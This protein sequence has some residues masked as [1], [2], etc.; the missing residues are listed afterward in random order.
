[1]NLEDPAADVT[2]FSEEQRKLLA[3]L[4]EEEGEEFVPRPAV[5]PRPPLESIPL[6][7]EQ[8]RLWFLWRL[9]PDTPFYNI[10]LPLRLRGWLAVPHLERAVNDVVRRHEILRTVFAETEQEPTQ[11]VNPFV[12][13]PLTVLDLSHDAE[14]EASAR[15]LAAEDAARPADLRQGP[16]FRCS[17]LKLADDEHMLLATMHHI[18]SDGW[19]LGVFMRE[20]GALYEGYCTGRPATL[21]PLPVQYADYAFWQRQTLSGETLE[22]ELAFCKK[23]LE[24][25]PPLLALP[26]DRPRPPVQTYNGSRVDFPLPAELSEGVTA[27]ARGRGCTPFMVLQA[28]FVALLSRYAGAEDVVVGY[29][30]A[31]RPAAETEGLIGL[32]TN[33]LLLRARLDD[34]PTF[35]EL[36]ERVKESVLDGEAHQS[37][38]FEKLVEE[39]RPP[40]DPS[41]AP[42]FQ[43]MFAY[44]GERLHPS[45]HRLSV[46]PLHVG[47]GTAKFDLS[48]TVVESRRGT[49]ASMEYNSDLFERAT[50]ER[51]VETFKRLLGEVLRRPEGRVARLP[52]L[53]EAERRLMLRVGDIGPRLERFQSV[54]RIFEARAERTPEAV[55]L[56][57][58]AARLTYRELNGRANQLAHYLRARGVGAET[59]VGLCLDKSPELIVGAL[60]ILKAG[61]VYVPL[62]PQYPP[63]RLA[64]MCEDA[65]LWG[66]LSRSSVAGSLPA[67]E[68]RALLFLDS[69]W[70]QVARESDRN[71][72]VEV[73]GDNL[74]YV[75]YTSGSTGRPKGVGVRHAS[76]STFIA[77]ASHAYEI[78]PGDRVLQFSSIN[79]DASAE[80]IYCTL[81]R[82]ATLVLRTDEMMAGIPAF[83][84]ECAESGVTVLDLPTAFW[85]EITTA[86]EAEPVTL[87]PTLRLVLFGGEKMLAGHLQSWRRHA[88][89]HVRVL[90]A[91]GPTE[92]TILATLNDVSAQADRDAATAAASIGRP[93]QGAQP[94]V[95]D[96]RMQLSLVGVPGELHI[97]GAGLARGYLGRP[98]LTAERFVPHPFADAPGE[99]LYRTGDLVRYLPDGTLEF[100]GRID[101]QVKVRGFR[102]ELGEIENALSLHPSVQEAAVVFNEGD[103]GGQLVAYV[104]LAAEGAPTVA[105][106]RE[107]LRGRLPD[108]MVPAA[109]V[110]LPAFPLTP[111]GKLDRGALPPPPA[112]S[113][114]AGDGAPAP[115]RDPA[116]ELLAAL[117]G[118]LLGAGRVGRHDNF[119]DLGGHS[120]L[121][122]RLVSRLR[123]LFGVEL[124]LR[125]LFDHPTPAGLAE[126]LRLARAG[127][128]RGAAAPPVVARGER[129]APLSYA[130]QRLWFL[131]QLEAEGAAY[132]MASAVRLRGRLDA[133]ALEAAL[134]E[135]VRRHEVLRSVIVAEGG[136]PAQVVDE[137][138]LAGWRLPVEALGGGPSGGAE[139]SEGG[140]P[141]EWAE[142]SPEAE[143]RRE[144]ALSRLLREEAGRPFRLGREWP[145]RA[146]LLRLSE[147]E[148]VLL[149]VL[150]HAAADGWS[151][152]VL[153]RELG[154]LYAAYAG[155]A[156]GAVL[157]ELG[158][159]YSDYAAWQREW[160]GGGELGRQVEYWRGRLE[161][162]G[163]GALALPA[164]RE[165]GAAPSGR[166]AE[167]RVRV[168][169]E[170]AGGLREVGRREGATPFML[171]L[172]GFYALLYRYTGRLDITVGVPIAGR[173]RAEF[174]GLIGFFTNTLALRSDLRGDMTFTELLHQTREIAL[175][176]Y[177][178]QDVPFEKLVEELQV[179]RSLSHHPLFQVMF[180]LQN[181]PQAAGELA[182]LQTSRVE[183]EHNTAKFDLSLM[184]RESEDG[185]EGW[186]EY[187][188]D[189][190]DES[191]IRRMIGHLNRLLEGAA[192]DPEARISELPLL[193]EAE[194]QQLALWNDTAADFPRDATL[195][196]LF[197]AQVARTPDDIALVHGRQR[198]SYRELDARA[199][200]IAGRLRSRGVGPEAR[201]GVLMR[202][203][204]D[205]L[206]ALLGVLKAGGAYVPLDPAYPQERL[207]FMLEDAEA[208]VLLTQSELRDALP[209]HAGGV[210]YVDELSGDEPREGGEPRGESVAAPRPYGAALP[211]NLAYV[212]Y[213]SGSTGR[214]KGAMVTQAGVVNCLRAMQELYNLGP[215]DAFLFN[216]SLSF[217]PSVWEVFWPLSVGARVVVAPPGHFDARSLAATAAHHGVTSLYLVPSMLRAFLEGLGAD[218]TVALRR[219]L[220]RLISGGESLP[221]ELARRC[222]EQL[223]VELH[224]SYGPTET[225]IA[226]CESL[227]TSDERR[228]RVPIGRPLA[229]NC[230]YVLDARMRPVPVGVAGELYVGG[231]GVGRGYLNRPA[232][233]AERFVP[234][235]FSAEPGARLYRTGDVVRYL[236]DGQLEFVGRADEQLK[237]R[238]HRIEPGEVE[239]ALGAHP[240]VA[241][242]LV[243]AC[244]AD[245]GERQL[246]A[247]VVPEAGTAPA[248][249]ELRAHLAGGLPEYMVPSRIVML[250]ALPLLP[251]GKVDRRALPAPDGTRDAA[252]PGYLSPRN[253]LETQLAAIWENV[254]DVRP[255]GVRDNFFELGG[256]SLAAVRMMAQI[257]QLLGHE[258]PLATVFQ[259]GTV[260][261]FAQLLGAKAGGGALSPLVPVQPR[262]GLPPFFAIHPGGGQVLGYAPLGRR[263]APDQPL[264]GLQA[265][266][267]DGSREPYASIEEMAA[268]YIE[269]V[270][271]RQPA[272]PYHIGGLS[273]G[274]VVAFEMAQQLRRRGEEVALLALFDTPSPRL[275][276]RDEKFGDIEDDDVAAIVAVLIREE[277]RRR[278]KHLPAKA[279]ELRA[280]DGEERLNYVI[281]FLREI[282]PY[283]ELPQVRHGVNTFII[284][285][286]LLRAYEPQVYDGRVTLF[287]AEERNEEDARE[288]R[289]LVDEEAGERDPTLGWGVLTPEPVRVYT[290]PG[291]HITISTEPNVGVLAERLRQALAESRRGTPA[292]PQ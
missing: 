58:G 280:L 284:G 86:F 135:V 70:E 97:G 84:R 201:V 67:D 175:D 36:L 204:P 38:P 242:A 182:G 265:P 60:G 98:G 237:V 88:P 56:V 147:R 211:E 42:L 94:L 155:G 43:V 139:P 105:E 141:S 27:L 167:A 75:I 285:M 9:E 13:R 23:Q 131:Q 222:I 28:A 262:G 80:E 225:S 219:S 215:S 188:T 195:V 32:F 96:R 45:L 72:E 65:Q 46:S 270:R 123:R 119:F 79:F 199:E 166:G 216:T 40:R 264:Y 3:Y 212:I 156:S 148:H 228:P 174:E 103:G 241:Q 142:A 4:L 238:G 51:M 273:F 66:V 140:E 172:A 128:E 202:R 59:R 244:E 213:T 253:T 258:L 224:H 158:V 10:S 227:C 74:C 229:N 146:R 83:M 259:N 254:L 50:V 177:A 35:L 290:I 93:F 181:A 11:V 210:L 95:L 150:H 256:H 235:L 21:A 136:E 20:L 191:T 48:L 183:I 245:A 278:G 233:T 236:A 44:Q 91:Y 138:G 266:Y 37:L 126:R 2:E 162:G 192:A 12:Y 1:M 209:P 169:A 247:Y 127:A 291:D 152:G 112:P 29:P 85:H 206:A 205:M 168:G 271:A 260:E 289:G 178:H 69:D 246:V 281:G 149:L 220:R 151:A 82:G 226:A 170:V 221:S 164:D 57:Y 26:T 102:V 279:E 268:D 176:A 283:V 243:V 130:Q 14:R 47:S 90:N 248:A 64:F 277:G 173:T 87:P 34:E 194:R 272:G 17:L 134:R 19:S 160:L 109:F 288:L 78:T 217:D 231:R 223:G 55:A 257:Q 196:D 68:R 54:H 133:G 144:A 81:T 267:F 153:A 180:A 163:G 263:L 161:G 292:P 8:Q 145:L 154:A 165:R 117:W 61:G 24:G 269:A 15:R 107:Y 92:A 124:P 185:F 115:P 200:A 111:G 203:S 101:H 71:P 132:N 125:A 157:G 239:A 39:L 143:A 5:V 234:D 31:N 62:D 187:S 252:K 240:G 49:L 197:E 186:L 214:P 218:A 286:N 255:V 118:E 7:F 122:T 232:L 16:L 274:G 89:P 207:G 276:R 198:L 250:D 184:M 22:A 282:N 159:Q 179:E 104:V 190:F 275:F 251:N 76:L 77:A 137:Q 261:H 33:T 53:T 230:V 73:S 287:R 208:A 99:R 249:P 171:L 121:A 106:L 63:G 193:T 110:P 116:E 114:A 18:I 113:S 30:A 100:V 25:A 52:L 108:Y 6:S 129:R 189:L 120:L 41:Y